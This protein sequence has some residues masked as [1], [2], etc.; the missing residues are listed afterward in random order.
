MAIKAYGI[1]GCLKAWLTSE[2]G[3]T[4][5]G[6]L[7]NGAIQKEIDTSPYSGILITQSGRQMFYGLF[8]EKSEN[9]NE[10]QPSCEKSEE[11]APEIKEDS[12]APPESKEEEPQCTQCGKEEE[13]PKIPSFNDGFSW[14]IVSER[15]F[16][17][18]L[19][20]I[21]Y[22]LSHRAF[23]NAF[24]QHGRYFYGENGNLAA[25]AV[26]CD[27]KNEPHPFPTLTDFCAYRDG[28]MI[29][30]VDKETDNFRNYEY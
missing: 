19:R 10:E 2:N 24:L 28:C 16:P 22:I 9:V 8:R 26:E 18:D 25:I 14:R 6:N 17:S 15:A 5:I 29:I 23:Y 21:K 3:S 12:P 7:V 4:E 20:P 1:A 27:I 11:N 13:A 30:V